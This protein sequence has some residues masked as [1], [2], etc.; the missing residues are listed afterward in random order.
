MKY[1]ISEDLP[2]DFSDKSEDLNSKQAGFHDV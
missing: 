1:V 2:K